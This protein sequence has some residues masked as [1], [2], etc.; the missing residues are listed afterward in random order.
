MIALLVPVSATQLEY[1]EAEDELSLRDQEL[2]GLLELVQ[3]GHR[4]VDNLVEEHEESEEVS[5]SSTS[6]FS[7]STMKTLEE[8]PRT[9]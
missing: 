3:Y 4:D 9:S 1:Q 6:S 2:V 8:V 7:S 5:S